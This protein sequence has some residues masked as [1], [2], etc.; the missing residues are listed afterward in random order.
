VVPTRDGHIVL[1]AYAEEHWARFCQVVGREDL[2]TD[3][4]FCTNARRVENRAA[5]RAL[6]KECLSGLSSAECVE[7]L[8][9][10][11]IVAGAVRSYAQVLDNPDIEASGILVD[12]LAPDGSS[13][14]A[15]GLPY[16]FGDAARAAPPAAP[17]GGADSDELLREAG[18]TA[19]QI[20]GLRHAGAVA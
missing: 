13:Y 15:V 17:D 20:A 11:Q 14:R 16:R 1:S 9:R 3:P 2:V 4:R 18:Y 19:D 7:L 6:L 10:K 12:T 8:G 5:L